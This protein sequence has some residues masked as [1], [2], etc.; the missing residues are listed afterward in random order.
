MNTSETLKRFISTE[1]LANRQDL[2]LGPDDNLLISGLIDS[3][4]VMRLVSFIEDNFGV[5][6]PP[7]DVTIENFQS[8]SILS[9]YLESRTQVTS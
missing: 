4:G 2:N 3:L 8:I 9:A 6:V 7:E 1:L 5:H